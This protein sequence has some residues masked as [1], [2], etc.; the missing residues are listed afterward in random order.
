[1]TTTNAGEKLARAILGDVE[2]K[3]EQYEFEVTITESGYDIDEEVAAKGGGDIFFSI[4]TVLACSLHSSHDRSSSGI[5]IHRM[6]RE[7]LK[8]IRDE[9]SRFLED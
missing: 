4:D 3:P 2:K 7:H 5:S 9:I 6:S 8:Y 1:M